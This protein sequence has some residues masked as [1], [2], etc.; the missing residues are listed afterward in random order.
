MECNY[1]GRDAEWVENKEIYGRNYGNSYMTWLCR[2]CDAYVG[3]HHNTKKPLG[4]MSN[5]EE[6]ELKKEVKGMYLARFEKYGKQ[7]YYKH[8]A[9]MLEITQQEAHFG[10]FDKERLL[11]LKGILITLP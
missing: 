8:L 7:W 11:K 5:K 9:E 2:H 3:C 4:R 10:M 1:C 6:R